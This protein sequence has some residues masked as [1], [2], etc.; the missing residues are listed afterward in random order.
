M[1]GDWIKTEHATP[2]KPE[3]FR[4]AMYLEIAPEHVLGCLT[5]I[6]IWADQQT[7]NGNGVCVTGVTLDRIAC[8][9][10]IAEAMKKVG[11]LVG[12]EANYSFPN[13]DRHNGNTS[14]TRAVTAKR[15]AKH[16]NADTVTGV[17]I[18]TLP[19]KR[20]EEKL[21]TTVSHDKIVFDGSSFQNVNGQLAIWQKAYPALDI[22]IELNKAAAWIAAN[23]KNAKSNYARFLTNWLSRA[24]D[25]APKVAQSS[26]KFRGE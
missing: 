24:Q 18:Q 4:M 20:R 11:W 25:K 9:A 13:F 26:P 19:E 21:T 17:T 15:V 6:W 5:R 14:K 2:D 3:V 16:R 1:A 22:Q 7:L 23:P 8:Y 12:D 10:G